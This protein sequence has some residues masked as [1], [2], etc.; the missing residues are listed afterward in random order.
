MEVPDN[1][2]EFRPITIE[3]YFMR[4]FHR[5]LASCLKASLPSYQDQVCFKH[6]DEIAFNVVKLYVA[7]SLARSKYENF[8]VDSVDTRKTFDS[9]SHE[10]LLNI[11][12]TEGCPYGGIGAHVLEIVGCRLANI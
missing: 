6:L 3:N 8:A 10:V 4:V 2:L 5:V 12:P 1:P 7:L 9:I 11:I